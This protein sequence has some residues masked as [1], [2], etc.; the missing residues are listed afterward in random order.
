MG[1]TDQFMDMVDHQ[2]KTHHVNLVLP[3]HD[4]DNAEI[5]QSVM[6]TVEQQAAVTASPVNV[7]PCSRDEF[8]NLTPH[9]L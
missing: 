1:R 5:D 2:A 4:R 9:T 3:G 7:L 6:D 8:S